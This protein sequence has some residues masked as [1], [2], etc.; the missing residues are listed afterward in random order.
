M[1]CSVDDDVVCRL[2]ASPEKSSA[3]LAC[4]TD[5][6][7]YSRWLF[8]DRDSA[9]REARWLDDD[10]LALHEKM[11]GRDLGEFFDAEEPRAASTTETPA[12]P[13]LHRLEG[14]RAQNPRH[15]YRTHRRSGNPD[16][17]LLPIL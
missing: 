11:L 13:F 7:P 3:S 16:F 5:G 2:S 9:L 8:A 6:D 10:F 4:R 15:A 14:D 17:G 12:T 1:F